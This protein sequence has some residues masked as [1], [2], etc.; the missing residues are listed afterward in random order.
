LRRFFLRGAAP[1]QV[2]PILSRFLCTP[3]DSA[4]PSGR[5]FPI[6]P[7]SLSTKNKHRAKILHQNRI[8]KN[9]FKNRN[10]KLLARAF[11]IAKKGAVQ[12]I[13]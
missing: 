9:R 2:T 1:F 5:P 11:F 12:I 3:S 4:V 13:I 7:E 10:K 6:H 8:Q